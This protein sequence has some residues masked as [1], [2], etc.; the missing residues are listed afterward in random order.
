MNDAPNEDLHR[1]AM[2]G[3]VATYAAQGVKLALQ[4]ASV[5]ILSRLLR[6]ADF[7]LMAMA[8]PVWALAM[9]L[10]DL[11]FTQTTIQ[12]PAI[13]RV[14]ISALFWINL[15]LGGAIAL[16]LALAAPAVG[17][18]YG[19]ARVSLLVRGFSVV[20]VLGAAT[21]QHMAVMAREM[22]F[23]YLATLDMGAYAAGVAGG[24]A[25]AVAHH[26]YLALFAVP[27]ITTLTTAIGAWVGAGFLPLAPQRP[28]GLRDLLRM[29]G[30]IAGFNVFNFVSR[31][32]DNVLIGFAWG[33]TALG[34]YDRAY[35]LLLF[36]MQQVNAPL[37]R[38]MIPTL[39]RLHDDPEQY[40]RVYLRAIQQ[41]LLITQPGIVFAIL[42]ADI[43]VPTL[44][45]PS[46]AG[47][48]PIFQWL[49]AAALQQPLVASTNWLFVSQGRSGA[50]LVWGAFNAATSLA[51]FLAGLPW[52]PVGVAAAYSITQILLRGP[53][54]WWLA[55][56]T[57]PVLH[58]DILSAAGPHALVS[59]VA[60][61]AVLTVRWSSNL[62]GIPALMAGATASYS[63]MVLTMLIL[64]PGRKI[65]RDTGR[66]A[67]RIL[68]R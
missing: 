66:L 2:R 14:Q 18:F 48:A 64:P 5:V 41:L 10:Q 58:R 21:A 27:L 9:M 39:S 57:G 65:M 30:G 3:V 49:G 29:G 51:A 4:L 31:N 23:R 16:T 55:T 37:A 62:H 6:P 46:W 36:P 63:A 50:Y 43:L 33:K 53:V 15:A 20:I 24:I 32:M 22:R 54:M 26:S 12:R 34:R 17:R 25:V 40:R 52:G 67:A 8:T 13:T 38:V 45:G 19:D 59:G 44:L 61:A 60:A 28:P 35:K 11:G 56:R 47:T 68:A 42:T 1:R 7:G